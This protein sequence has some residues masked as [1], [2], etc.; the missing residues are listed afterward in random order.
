MGTDTGTD[1]SFGDEMK[2]LFLKLPNQCL[3]TDF[4]LETGLK[5]PAWRP[6]CDALVG[7]APCIDILDEILDELTTLK[8]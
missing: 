4:N 2:I 5:I 7:I 6:T 8:N 3:A 1:N